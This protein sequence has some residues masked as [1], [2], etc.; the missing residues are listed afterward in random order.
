[1]SG[2]V[3][4]ARSAP[5][6]VMRGT[7][8]FARGRPTETSTLSAYCAEKPPPTERC[9]ATFEIITPQRE[10]FIPQGVPT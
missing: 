7:S 3:P 6:G 1:M 8:R 10:G 2:T 5:Y 9:R 4:F